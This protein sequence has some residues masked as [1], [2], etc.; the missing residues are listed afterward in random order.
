MATTTFKFDDQTEELIRDLMEAYGATTKAELF[1]LALGML[2][3]IQHAMETGHE[4]A[5][6]G[7]DNKPRRMQFMMPAGAGLS[8]RRGAASQNGVSG[9]Q[10]AAHVNHG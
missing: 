2:D 5:L 6:I 9:Q 8:K 7:N 1:R 10:D 4:V 3:T